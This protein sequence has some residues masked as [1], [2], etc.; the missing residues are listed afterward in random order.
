M[1]LLEDCQLESKVLEVPH[2]GAQKDR[3]TN[4]L[5]TRNLR[6]RVHGQPESRHYCQ[7]CLRV[8]ED[9][10]KVWVVVI[11]GVTVGCPCCGVH[12]C[13]IPL[14]NNRH[15]F[16]PDHAAQNKVCA[17]V[18]CHSSATSGSRTCTEA[19]HQNVE[20]IYRERGQARFQLKE[21]LERARVAHLNDAIA[22]DRELTELADVDDE[23]EEFEVSGIPEPE[24]QPT[25]KERIRAQFGRRRTHNEQIVVSPCGMIIGRE[26]FFGAEGVG[27]VIVRNFSLYPLTVLNNDQEMIRRIFHEDIKPDHVFFDNNCTLAKMVK[28]DPFFTDIGLTVDVFH[29]KSKHSVTDDF[30]QEHC[31]PA[32]YPELIS[33]DNKGWYFNSSIA[34]QT[35]VW[36]GGYHAICREMHVDK[37]TFFL[38]E[39]ILRRNR[40]TNE[41]L[42]KEGQSPSRW[43]YQV[44]I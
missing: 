6:F 37:Y 23:T 7:K 40:M 44:D 1:S 15:H 12:N 16:C 4:A 32:A 20:H 43:P 13:K 36:L 19:S 25:K 21:Q 3:F 26:T 10:K 17:V 9:G 41:K 22:E 27:S 35:N 8:Y 11:D 42:M 24:S 2:T 28:D 29:F 39:M 33:Q 14:E 38:D 5:R 34:E 18:G 31:N 30:C